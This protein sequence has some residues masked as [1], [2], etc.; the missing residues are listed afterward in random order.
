[1]AIRDEPEEGCEKVTMNS[2]SRAGRGTCRFSA[3]T[4]LFLLCLVTQ[5]AGQDA[6]QR[7]R[8]RSIDVKGSAISLDD[9]IA[10]CTALIVS[11]NERG[12]GLAEA[13]LRRGIGAQK[14]SDLARALA[15]YEQA[16][17]IDASY[18][19][20]YVDKGNLKLRQGKIEEAITDFNTALRIDPNYAFGY[21][22]R[23]AAFQSKGDYDRALVNYDEALRLD[24]KNSSFYAERGWVH[25]LK[26]DDERAITDL[27]QAISL[28]PK[29]G[30]AYADRGVIWRLKRDFTRAMA[31]ANQS[32]QTDGTKAIFY[33]LRGHTWRAQDNDKQA[34]ADFETAIR[35]DPKSAR[36]FAQR[37]SLHL[38]NKDWDRAIADY[39][40]ALSF[41]PKLSYVFHERGFAWRNKGDAERALADYNEAIRLNPKEVTSYNNRGIIWR[42]RGDFARAIADFD[43]AVRVDPAYGAAFTNRG[44]AY[45]AKGEHARA[46]S[47]F[48]TALV[49]P[50]KYDTGNWSQETARARLKLL[51][52]DGAGSGV[53]TGAKVALVI[54]NGAYTSVAPLPNPANDARDV[55]KTFREIGFEVLQGIDLDRE[56]QEKLVRQFLRKASTARIAVVFYAGHGMQVNGKNYLLPVDAKINAQ[57]DL[58]RETL[59]LNTMLDGLNDESRTNIVILDACRDN[60]FG[61][62]GPAKLRSSAGLAAVSSV[63]VGTLVVFATAPERA[64]LDGAGTNSPFT[65]ALLKHVRTPGLE[66]RQML[67]KVRT[68]V[69]RATASKQ[70]PWD[71]SSLLGD[72]YLV[73]S[74]G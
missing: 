28:D 40:A 47:D 39:N 74:P 7:E 12:R 16:I 30:F 29:N 14:K 62:N 13:H 31:D 63:S 4:G 64:A 52:A 6:Q 18:I 57:T 27:N 56:R 11:G 50:P 42:S 10:G 43:S 23:G 60:P 49:L 17:R 5:A 24:P 35:I 20:P 21:A 69:T 26:S 73:G 41:D 70:V 32:I 15:D 45:E 8:C 38:K 25:H 59:E 22:R 48:E 44:L 3:F 37:G 19:R 1:M 61:A 71:N 46:R 36:A 54:G 55:A 9:A 58:S 2:K 66:V 72:V 65:T 53:G 33:V 67:S 68:E 34:M 51:S